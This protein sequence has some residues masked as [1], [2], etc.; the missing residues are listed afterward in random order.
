MILDILTLNLKLEYD[1]LRFIIPVIGTIIAFII[2]WFPHKSQALKDKLAFKYGNDKGLTYHFWGTK[3][4]GAISF[5]LLTYIAYKIAF[6]ET[7]LADLG[8]TFYKASI[9]HTLLYSVGIGAILFFVTY[10]NCK[11]PESLSNYPQIRAKVWTKKM[12]VWTIVAWTV[13]LLGYEFLFRGV[14][15]FPLVAKVGLWPAIAVNT[16][17]YSGTHVPKGLSETIGAF[18][19]GTILCLL[20]I[21]TGTIWIAFL[22][23]LVMALTNF[24]ASLKFNA[25]MVIEKVKK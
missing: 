25:D 1:D 24:G 12:I 7:K 20:T 11:K 22:T 16:A 3:F 13:Y 6:P 18:I 4:L 8:F 23:H 15:L 5:G 14:L 21:Y 2:A 19:L 10:R 17:L 9:L